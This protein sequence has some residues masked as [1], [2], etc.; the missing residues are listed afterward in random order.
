MSKHRAPSHR[1]IRPVAALLASFALLQLLPSGA[2]G[3]TTCA[4]CTQEAANLATS[5]AQQKSQQDLLDRNRAYLAAIKAEDLSKAV[6]VR[7][8]I[9]ILTVR[10]ETTKNNIESARLVLASKECSA[11]PRPKK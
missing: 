10:I 2:R 8:N 6:K 7:S 3:A 9:L 4:D 5:T 1:R 11:C